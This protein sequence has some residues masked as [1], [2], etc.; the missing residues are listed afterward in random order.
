MHFLLIQEPETV[1]TV[2]Y[3]LK[4]G[5]EKTVHY[6]LSLTAVLGAGQ[7]WLPPI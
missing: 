3:T 4:V 7:Q 2:K 5:P 1:V 6:I